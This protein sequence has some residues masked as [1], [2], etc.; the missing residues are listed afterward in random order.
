L[1][2]AAG[3]EGTGASGLAAG[4][5]TMQI[6]PRSTEVYKRDDGEGNWA[7]R[8]WHFLCS[9]LAPADEPRP[10]FGDTFADRG[11]GLMFCGR[12]SRNRLQDAYAEQ[13][14]FSLG[15]IG[16]SGCVQ[17]CASVST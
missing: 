11:R 2:A 1:F 15:A 9:P 7:W 6:P 16:L 14:G 12:R 8:M 5:E 17:I 13:T 3:A 10:G 4:A